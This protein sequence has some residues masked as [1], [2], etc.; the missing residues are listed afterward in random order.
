[1]MIASVGQANTQSRHPVQGSRSTFALRLTSMF[2]IGLAKG[3]SY[4][5]MA[6]SSHTNVHWSHPMQS[7]SL[8]KATVP[9]PPFTFSRASVRIEFSASR[10]RAASLSRRESNSS[11]V[12]M[13]DGG[14]PFFSNLPKRRMSAIVD[15]L[16]SVKR[17]RILSQ[18]PSPCLVDHNPGR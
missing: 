15:V 1:M 17:R 2:K 8:T 3:V 9:G 11:R 10:I 6:S 5:S 18:S 12:V 14:R 16:K 4:N 13:V 7:S